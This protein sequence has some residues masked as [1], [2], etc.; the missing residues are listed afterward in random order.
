[1][2][3]FF[4]F[5]RGG[6]ASERASVVRGSCVYRVKLDDTRRFV[7]SETGGNVNGARQ[8]QQRRQMKVGQLAL[9]LC[10]WLR[11]RGS[12]LESERYSKSAL[13]SILGGIYRLVSSS[14]WLLHTWEKT[15]ASV[16]LMNRQVMNYASV[17][18]LGSQEVGPTR[19]W[20]SRENGRGGAGSVPFAFRLTLL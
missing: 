6:R 3:C 14:I 9:L 18:C 15:V 8:Q 7:S 19:T 17:V 12:Y 16:L 13:H 10:S 11:A 5:V 20:H 1:M 2:L 4:A